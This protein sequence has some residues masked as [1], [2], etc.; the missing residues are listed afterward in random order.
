MVTVSHG[1]P[2]CEV[3]GRSDTQSLYLS[4]VRHL[5]CSLQIHLSCNPGESK[6]SHACQ[7]M[8]N[9]DVLPLCPSSVALYFFPA[10]DLWISS[11][12]DPW[13]IL[14]FWLHGSILHTL[15]CVLLTLDSCWCTWLACGTSF[16]YFQSLKLSILDLLCHLGMMYRLHLMHWWPYFIHN[17]CR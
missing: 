17:S 4:A 13:V 6:N 5:I 14:M 2:I 10:W 16:S 1:L 12:P 15:K 3:L 11:S 7:K 8:I 9:L